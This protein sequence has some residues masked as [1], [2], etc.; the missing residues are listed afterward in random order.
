[1]RTFEDLG[2]LCMYNSYYHNG[3][4][5]LFARLVECGF[6]TLSRIDASPGL[7]GSCEASKLG[8]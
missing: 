7:C 4:T 5:L 1:M 3:F 8:I 2:V 6:E